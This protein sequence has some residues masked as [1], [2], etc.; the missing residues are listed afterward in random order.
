MKS[1]HALVAFLAT[2]L[3]VLAG[4][5]AFSASATGGTLAQ[6][7]PSST[8]PLFYSGQGSDP[9][10]VQCDEANT[11]YLLFVLTGMSGATNISLNG[12][13]VTDTKNPGHS[14]T[15]QFTTVY[16]DPS[17]L[18]NVVNATWDGTVGNAQLVISHGCPGST[19]SSPPT[20]EPTSAPPSS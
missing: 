12:I 6:A 1:K 2:I 13:T 9:L 4:A 20:T 3:V 17:S 10:D 15:W 8:S 19:P 11:P 16:E 18:I 7:P 5:F 14:G